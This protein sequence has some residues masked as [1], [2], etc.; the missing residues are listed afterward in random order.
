VENQWRSEPKDGWIG[1]YRSWGDEEE[2]L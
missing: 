1:T 2:E